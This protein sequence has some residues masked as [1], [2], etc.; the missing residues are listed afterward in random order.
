MKKWHLSRNKRKVFMTKMEDYTNARSL[1]L[2]R[3]WENQSYIKR[4]KNI[5]KD[6]V[7]RINPQGFRMAIIPTFISIEISFFV[8]VNLS[9]WR[10][11]GFTLA[12]TRAPTQ[13][14]SMWDTREVVL[15]RQRRLRGDIKLGNL[16]CNWSTR[17][18]DTKV[19][20][21]EIKVGNFCAIIKW[22][23]VLEYKMV[24]LPQ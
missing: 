15:I 24:K 7:N 21:K 23:L 2:F 12:K 11:K 5:T 20:L 4:Q 18:E 17:K 22:R 6:E 13:V 8:M 14:L 19:W 16:L 3:R 10:G 9:S 1:F